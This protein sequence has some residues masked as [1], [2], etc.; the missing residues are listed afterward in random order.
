MSAEWLCSIA[1]VRLRITACWP[2]WRRNTAAAASGNEAARRIVDRHG[3]DIGQ[4]VVAV[5]SVL[6]PGLV[7]LGG[8]VGQNQL[9]LPEV[10][11]TVSQLAWPTE[12]T[13]GALGDY[14]TV[15]GAVHTAITRALRRMV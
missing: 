2:S 4:A 15:Q 5:M 9:L 13:V 3:R 7:V 10:R 14:A 8:G 11:K 6:D 12:I 1:S